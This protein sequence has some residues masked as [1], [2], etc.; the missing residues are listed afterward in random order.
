MPTPGGLRHW[1]CQSG[2]FDSS[3]ACAPTL[4]SQKTAASAIEPVALR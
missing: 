1:L 4:V 2:Y 3:K